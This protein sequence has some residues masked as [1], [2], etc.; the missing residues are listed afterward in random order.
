MAAT[1]AT[2]FVNAEEEGL[3]GDYV[4]GTARLRIIKNEFVL[5]ERKA[6]VCCSKMKSEFNSEDRIVLPEVTPAW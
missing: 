6:V 5:S 3:V 1:V 4:P 2:W